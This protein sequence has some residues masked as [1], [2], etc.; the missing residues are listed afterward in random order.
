M[1]PPHRGAAAAALLLACCPVL[2]ACGAAPWAGSSPSPT[3][4]SDTFYFQD[5]ALPTPRQ[6]GSTIDLY[7]GVRYDAGTEGAEIPD[8]RRLLDQARAYLTP[9][10]TLPA[11][12]SWET[13]AAA[14]APDLMA[15]GPMS[16][17]TVQ[18]RVH[19]RCDAPAGERGVWRSAVHT[20]GDIEPM[21]YVPG[22]VPACPA[23]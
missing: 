18:I 4:E 2:A 6:G 1:R 12:V 22:P 14:M 19:P 23:P 5:T 8:Y 15:A 10:E 11:S 20:V 13:L 17:V 21:D 7:V 9:T 3:R 16:G